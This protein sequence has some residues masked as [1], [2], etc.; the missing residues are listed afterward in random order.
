LTAKDRTNQTE[1]A[2][3]IAKHLKLAIQDTPTISSIDFVLHENGHPHALLEVKCRNNSR[4]MY[5]DYMVD[6]SK[7]DKLL[8]L[9]EAHFLTG[10]F[11]VRFTDCIGITN[12]ANFIKHSRVDTGWRSGRNDPNDTDTCYFFNPEKFNTLIP[13]PLTLN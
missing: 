13:W 5:P 8:E 3:V 6:K 7:I 4:L 10:L 11:A 12:P 2:E 1:V 9:S